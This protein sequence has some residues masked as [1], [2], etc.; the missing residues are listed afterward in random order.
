MAGTTP[1]DQAFPAITPLVLTS[2]EADVRN[3]I[4]LA[5]RWERRAWASVVSC[6]ITTALALLLAYALLDTAISTISGIRYA[7][8]ICTTAAGSASILYKHVLRMQEQ[9]I[10]TVVELRHA[11]DVAHAH[12]RRRISVEVQDELQSALIRWRLTSPI[13]PEVST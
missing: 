13:T 10:R 6:A 4:R 2:D 1:E 8:A 5:K 12:G 11:Q 7:N 9:A 3:A